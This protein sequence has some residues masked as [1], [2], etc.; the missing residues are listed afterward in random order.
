MIM[1]Y[2]KQKKLLLELVI[3]YKLSTDRPDI[4][5]YLS[6]TLASACSKTD[7]STV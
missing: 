2:S 4:S 3:T 6:R 1:R 7:T 5:G